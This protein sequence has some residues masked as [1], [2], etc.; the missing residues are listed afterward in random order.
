MG[1][2]L[3]PEN[4]PSYVETVQFTPKLRKCN[5]NSEKAYFACRPILLGIEDNKTQNVLTVNR[6]RG[7]KMTRRTS[8]LRSPN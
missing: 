4:L 2:K 7:L 5:N 6:T 3:Q 1:A 8:V